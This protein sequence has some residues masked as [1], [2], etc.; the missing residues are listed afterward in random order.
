ME[1][2]VFSPARLHGAVSAPCSKSEAH[3]ALLLAALGRGECRLTEFSGELCGDTQAMLRGIRALGAD[4]VRDGGAIIVKPG[5]KPPEATADMGAC[6]A[7]L[8]MLIPAFA[9]KGL[10]CTLYMDDT[11]RLRPLAAFQAMSPKPFSVSVSGGE[12][13]VSGSLSAGEYRIDGS[14][15]SQFASG[16]LIAL[17]SIIGK[18]SRVTVV[19][20]IKSRSYLDLTL[21]MLAKFGA[22]AEEKGGGVFTV[23]KEFAD[24][25]SHIA[26]AGDFTQA[27]ALLCAGAAG[28][29]VIVEGLTKE[30][31][32]QGDCVIVDLLR[33]MGLRCRAEGDA[34]YASSPSRASIMPISADLSATPDIAPIVA[35]L[36][37]Q[38]RGVSVLS[39]LSA[40]RYK[41][42]DRLLATSE[43]LIALGANVARGEDTLTII[44]GGRLRGGVTLDARGDHRM[45]M[46]IAVAAILCQKPV[47]LLGA[48]AVSKSWPSFLDAYRSLG[49]SFV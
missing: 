36:L 17:S 4:C 29:G 33:R 48:E 40:L 2:L 15:S 34:V 7:A 26:L 11:L 31:W 47:T 38:A 41:E 27:A 19:P 5:G 43:I 1:R 49:G 6:A 46:L 20:P 12:A 24:N 32:K 25:P 10:P 14:V 39:G 18:E 37:T 13:R 30:S 16:L 23:Y 3:R 35:L 45:V 22:R 9:V 42:C 8:R 28:G 21:D 44:G